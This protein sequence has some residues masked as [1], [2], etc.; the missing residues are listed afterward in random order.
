MKTDRIFAQVI[1]GILTGVAVYLR[2]PV[3][4][5][6][7]VAILLGL[8]AEAII[9]AQIKAKELVVLEAQMAEL[10]NKVTQ[11]QKEINRMVVR[12]NEF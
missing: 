8:M 2:S 4:G 9:A 5:F 10:A 6:G 11:L 12:Q 1:T 3:L 7:A